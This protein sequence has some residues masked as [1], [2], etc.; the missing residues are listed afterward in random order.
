MAGCGWS[1]D[2]LPL[3]SACLWPPIR[4][5]PGGPAAAGRPATSDLGP[6]GGRGY[7]P[8]SWSRSARPVYRYPSAP[9]A[10]RGRPRRCKVQ[11][12][13]CAPSSL[14][15]SSTALLM[16]LLLAVYGALSAGA[17]AQ[18]K[19]PTAQQTVKIS[20]PQISLMATVDATSGALVEQIAGGSNEYQLLTFRGPR[21]LGVSL[22]PLAAR[23]GTLVR[24]GT[25]AAPTLT[26]TGSLLIPGR[27]ATPGGIFTVS[28]D[29]DYVG[30]DYKH[31]ALRNASSPASDCQAA[32]ESELHS[33]PACIAW[34]W[35]CPGMQGPRPNC[36]LKNRVQSGPPRTDCATSGVYVPPRPAVP[37][38]RVELTRIVRLEA[39][40]P[41]SGTVHI[42]HSLRCASA[43][44]PCSLSS[45]ED[46]FQAILGKSGSGGWYGEL[47]DAVWSQSIKGAAL[48]VVPHWN[49]KSPAL[50]VQEG[51]LLAALIADLGPP[52]VVKKGELPTHPRLLDLTNPHNASIASPPTM[53]YGLGQTAYRVHSIYA[54][55]PRE[56]I[57]IAPNATVDLRYILLLNTAAPDAKAG[58]DFAS[59]ASLLWEVMG[60]AALHATPHQQRGCAVC[61]NTQL[62]LFSS[63][64]GGCCVLFGGSFD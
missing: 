15:P 58:G 12:D 57:D 53:A 43:G 20:I 46:T 3:L 61:Q 34:V 45:F 44:T 62:D 40:G 38:T 30:G 28:K 60:S 55:T 41:T 5:A 56:A 49:F 33:S 25:Q 54:R 6:Q 22:Q 19:A 32:C 50:M 17:T 36:W 27:P 63:W 21:V 29:T 9:A 52:G 35:T 37:D 51:A 26:A 59:L 31:F 42:S 7:I 64:C 13:P 1:T 2:S 48:D 8:H 16:S 14:Q 23:W 24:G 39:R 11:G 4:R 47:P 10:S 18:R